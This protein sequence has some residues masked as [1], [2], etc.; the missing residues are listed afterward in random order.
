MKYHITRHFIWIFTV[1]QSTRFGVSALFPEAAIFLL[2]SCRIRYTI[3]CDA[4]YSKRRQ[5]SL[6]IDQVRSDSLLCNQ[7]E[8]EAKHPCGDPESFVRGG[9]TLT[10]PFFSL[11]RGGRI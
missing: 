5:I 6:Y 10:T 4:F 1:C 3:I 8:W 7:H 2:L 11:M 9:P